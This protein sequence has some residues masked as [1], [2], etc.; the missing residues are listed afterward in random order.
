MIVDQLIT[1]MPS[2][3]SIFLGLV[4]VLFFWRFKSP[5]KALTNFP[6]LREGGTDQARKS[7]YTIKGRHLYREGYEKFKDSIYRMVTT[8]YVTLVLPMK[9]FEELRRLP[10]DELSIDPTRE[11]VRFPHLDSITSR[12]QSRLVLTAGIPDVSALLYGPDNQS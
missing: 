8:D 9:Y 3:F 6:L 2:S 5:G 1:P 11:V 7:E 12:I 4:A 10:E